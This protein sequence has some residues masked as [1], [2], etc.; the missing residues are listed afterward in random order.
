MSVY[1]LTEN[2]IEE[3]YPV[4]FDMGKFKSIPSF[5]QRI[6][7]CV[8]VLGPSLGAGSSRRVFPIDDEKVLKLAMNKKGLAQNEA[9]C[10][11]YLQQTG[12]C[13]KVYDVDDKYRWIEMQKAEKAKPS[14]FKRLT[15]YPFKFLQ[16]FVSWAHT[17]YA[18]RKDWFRNTDYDEEI[19]ELLDS[20]EY[21]D[22]IFASIN[23]YMCNTGLEAYGDLQRIS[24][25]GIV[26]ENGQERLVL[27]DFGLNDDVAR[28]YYGLKLNESDIVEMVKKTISNLLNEEYENWYE[29]PLGDA[30]NNIWG[31]NIL[32]E[33]LND[34]ENGVEH[35][36]WDLI[37]SE[38]YKNLLQRYMQ[39]GDNARIPDRLMDNWIELICNNLVELDYITQFAGHSQYFPDEE[40]E[41][42]FGETY[43][44][45]RDYEGYSDFLENIGFYDW[46]Q[47]PDGSDAISDYGIRPIQDILQELSPASTPEEKLM[48]IN[49]CLSVIHCRGDLASAFIQGGRSTCSAISGQQRN[50]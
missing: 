30:Y 6:N 5:R 27:I 28:E 15:G 45:T 14:D 9:E 19:G 18:R 44:G 22:T 41:D 49:R 16:A 2:N 48:I 42:V 4:E 37:P 13:A 34:K 36:K 47:L 1:R 3:D 29:S 26:R 38:Q 32:Q 40:F 8:N 33:F 43:T 21:Y 12:I 23:D 17:Q 50:Y 11:W 25:W 46:A 31:G 10:D 20:D 35:K 39:F 7:Y 24:S